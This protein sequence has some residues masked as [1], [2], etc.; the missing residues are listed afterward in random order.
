MS[1][2]YI[3][4]QPDQQYLLPCALQEWLPQGHLAYFISDTVDSLNLSAFHVRYA[5]GGSRNQPFH[6]AMMVKVM[7]YAY[8]TGVFSSRKIAKKLHEDVAFRV[9]GAAN[10]PA[11]RT[12]R[13]FRA[14]HLNEFTELFIQVVRLAREM[15]LVKLGTIAVDGTKIKANASRHKAMSYGRMQTA[16]AELKAQITALVKKATSTDEAEK[17]EPDLD[18]PAEIERR[19]VRLAAIEAAKARLEERQRQSDAQRGRTPD[20]E[21]KPKDKDG[22]PKGG[23]PYQRDFGVPA[24]KEQD[25]FTDPQARIMKRAGGGF[26]YSYNAQ[27]AVD[28]AA[29]IIVVAEVVNT[30]SD[31]HQLPMVLSAVKTNTGSSAAQ[32]LADAGYRSEVV[33]AELAMTQPDTELVIALG[34]EG[35][36]LAKPRDAQR[37]PH[38]VAMAAK[39]ET[40]QGKADYRKRKWIAE[41]PNGWIK[42][43]LGFRQFSMR[44]LHKAQ[45]EFKLVCLALNLR[46][47]GAMQAC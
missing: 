26:D 32:A 14:L 17:N 42:N 34:R 16:E 19:Q 46:R 30:S 44:G 6:P 43:V 37:Y 20:D 18:I 28:E 4:Y 47:M 41:P 23:K 36:V 22:K 27:T 3:P 15:G 29:H 9:L 33:M 45:A 2:S 40:G 21:R 8:A 31:V 7:V 5:G 38:T 12:I 39:F 25:S 10:F 1:T 24:P 13:D 11:H 35:K